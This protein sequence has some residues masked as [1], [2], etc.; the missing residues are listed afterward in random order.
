MKIA[1]TVTTADT[2]SAFTIAATGKS[3][4]ILSDGL[5]SDKIRAIIRELACNARDSHVAAGN[6]APWHMHLPTYDEFWFSIEDF[7]TGMSHDDV[8]N[9]YSR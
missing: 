5:Y 8:M 2:N 1:D 9:V 6:A 3:F 4:K 7:G